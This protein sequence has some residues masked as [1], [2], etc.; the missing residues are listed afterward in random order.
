MRK[1]NVFVIKSL[2]TDVP[3]WAIFR[4]IVVFVLAAI[5]CLALL[6]AFPDIALV[7]TRYM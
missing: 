4:G 5:V 6:I 3:L 2:A 1:I 7:L